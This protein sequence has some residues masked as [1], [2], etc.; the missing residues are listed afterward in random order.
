MSYQNLLKYKNPCS[1]SFIE[2]GWVKY[3]T[4]K[5]WMINYFIIYLFILLELMSYYVILINGF[6]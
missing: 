6:M 5:L 1:S 4:R 2:D 3:F